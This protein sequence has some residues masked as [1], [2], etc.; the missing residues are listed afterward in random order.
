MMTI[1]WNTI[2][3]AALAGAVAVAAIVLTPVLESVLSDDGKRDE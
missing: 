3:Q 2:G 1:N